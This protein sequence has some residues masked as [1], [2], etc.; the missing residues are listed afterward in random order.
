MIIELHDTVHDGA[1]VGRG[2]MRAEIESM[3]FKRIDEARN[4]SVFVR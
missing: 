4:T 2:E 3:G 1:R